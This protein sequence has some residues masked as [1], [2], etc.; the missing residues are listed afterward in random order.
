[1]GQMAGHRVWSAILRLSDCRRRS[2]ADGG[3][4]AGHQPF[5][6]TVR[7]KQ[8]GQQALWHVFHLS[9]VFNDW[10][11]FR[12]F[13]ALRDDLLHGRLGAYLR[14]RAG[15]STWPIL[16]FFLGVRLRRRS[17]S[18]CVRG[19]FRHVGSAKLLNPTFLAFLAV[20]VISSSLMLS[21]T[22]QVSEVAPQGDTPRSPS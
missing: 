20:L 3:G 5:Q 6:W 8:Q 7:S 10:A 19:R 12:L 14:R 17:G 4:G 13:R 16:I 22:A 21:P 18:R 15:A 9:A 11:V 1:M 2:A